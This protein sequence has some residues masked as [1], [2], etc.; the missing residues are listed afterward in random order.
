MQKEYI[1][2]WFIL[3]FASAGVFHH[4]GIKIPYFAFFA[5]DNGWRV[6]EAPLHMLIAMGLAALLCVGLG[7]APDLLY[8]L[9]PYAIDYSPYDTAHVI[10]QLELLIFSALAFSTLVLSG[11]YPPEM[12]AINLDTD[13]FTRALPRFIIN[14]CRAPFVK[15]PFVKIQG[16]ALRR[17]QGLQRSSAGLLRGLFEPHGWFAAEHPVEFMAT[18]IFVLLAIAMLFVY[19]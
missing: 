10:S 14:L 18:W 13:W 4:S 7:V 9:L 1:I 6:R 2:V 8:G 5:H 11:V 16:W 15:I 3:L 19:N 12:R 17:G